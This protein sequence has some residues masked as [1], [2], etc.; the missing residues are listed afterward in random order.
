[1]TI[2][3]NQSE[4]GKFDMTNLAKNRVIVD[5]HN[6]LKE[7]NFSFFALPPNS[8]TPY[9]GG[10]GFKEATYAI[11]NLSRE[12]NL[13]AVVPD[14]YVVIDVDSTMPVQLQNLQFVATLTVSTPRGYH[15]YW[16]LPPG[17]VVK[18]A[19]GTTK[20]GKGVDIRASGLGYVVIPPSQINK[21]EYQ[22]GLIAGSHEL[23]KIELIPDKLLELLSNAPTKVGDVSTTHTIEK[24]QRNKALFSFASQLFKTKAKDSE[25]ARMIQAINRSCVKPPLD[26]IEIMVIVT[27]AKKYRK[28]N[29]DSVFV[30]RSRSKED[31][32]RESLNSLG[33]KLR[34]NERSAQVEFTNGAEWEQLKDGSEAIL[35]SDIERLCIM[36]P[37]ISGG[38][39]SG[40]K[41][42]FIPP[43]KFRLYSLALGSR[44]KVDPFKD[45]LE[46][47]PKWDGVKRIE[48][49]V[50]EIFESDSPPDLLRWATRYV[51]VGAVQRTYDPGCKLDEMVIL[52]G[53]QGVG[54]STFWSALLPWPELFSDSL[55]LSGSDRE[56]AESL[57]GKVIVECSELRGTRR[58]DTDS[59]K[60]F[61]SRTAENV[62]LAYNHRPESLPRRCIIVGTT[63]DEESLPNDPTGNRRFVPLRVTNTNSRTAKIKDYIIFNRDQ[64]WSEARTLYH[65]GAEVWLPDSLKGAQIKEA[66]THR[67]RDAYLES[68]VHKFLS[69]T[70]GMPVNVA[71]II[72]NIPRAH[73][74][75]RTQKEIAGILKNAGRIK[76]QRRSEGK[77]RSW[78]W[79]EKT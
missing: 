8:K 78:V 37:K 21:K 71:D 34:F 1:M 14:G 33:I 29:G 9:K 51:L 46:L 67:Y 45:Y 11:P 73:P 58:A 64:L 7:N 74:D 2:D 52:I 47:L 43:N 22:I 59:L 36:E 12:E 20:L 40:M 61:L 31:E 75:A 65:E 27:S 4:R 70:R 23:R 15:F 28:S 56:K 19:Q 38:K 5:F 41:P 60:A 26:A 68:K 44:S 62:R 16:K 50:S 76:V 3:K 57:L 10:K 18:Q 24:G 63:N 6:H 49:L 72:E 32:L 53:P 55:N 42:V 13:G 35:I 54:K 30:A 25:I 48:G 66:E 17:E 39:L 69:Q 79:T 77:K